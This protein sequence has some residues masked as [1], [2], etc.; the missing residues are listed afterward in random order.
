MKTV[1][2]IDDDPSFRKLITQWLGGAGWYV[3]EADDGKAGIQVVFELQPEAV[4][5]S[6]LMPGCNGFQICRAIRERA[7]VMEQPKIIVTT[8]SVY[9]ADRRS[10]IEAGADEYLVKPFKADDLIRILDFGQGR[11]PVPPSAPRTPPATYAPLPSDLPPRLKFWGVR[12]SI[13]TP[14]PGT[15][16]YGGNTS[17]VEIRAD[18]EIII[19]DA[20]SGIRPLGLALAQEFNNQPIN[21]TLL[22]THTHWDHIQGF[23]FFIPAYNPQNKVRIFGYEGARK[24]LHS[25]LTSQMESPYFPV[26]MRH[27][28]GNIDVTE[29]GERD[30]NIGKV[31]VTSAF[32][33]H[34]GICVGYRVFTSAGSIAYLPDNEPYQRLRSHSGGQPPSD[35]REGLKYASEQDQR[36]I[37]F[38]RDADV[39]II[40]SQY[41]DVEY[42]SHVGWGHGCVDDV[43]ALALFARVKQL[44]LFHH[45]PDHDDAQI[46]RMLDW[47][48]Q[49][50]AMHGEILVVDAAREGL[51]YVLNPVPGS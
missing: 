37:E 39:L 38:I 50:V 11:R 22:I 1:L 5:C 41:D 45:D 9:A 8:G 24:G 14:G 19:L 44:F 30:F 15:V 33:N 21:L 46:S 32:V 17:C 2:V 20:G 35:Y 29:L 47:A 43:V 12:G 16:L 26:S 10:A 36:I 13:P 40:D 42:Q 18:G 51:E 4:I 34:P 7:G 27:M 31:K 28:P 25:T 49:L 3:L 6:L 48:R 23:P